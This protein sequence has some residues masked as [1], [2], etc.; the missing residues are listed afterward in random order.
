MAV[1]TAQAATA[2]V[3][4]VEDCSRLLVRAA[5]AVAAAAAS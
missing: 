5:T 3:T 2:A 1:A 4:A